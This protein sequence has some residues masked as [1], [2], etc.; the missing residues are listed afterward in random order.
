[1]KAAIACICALILPSIP[2]AAQGPIGYAGLFTSYEHYEW[3]VDGEA[4]YH[5]EMWIWCFPSYLGQICAEFEVYYPPNVYESAITWNTPLISSWVGCPA[6]G[7]SVCFI[8]CQW[9][10]LWICHQSLWVT[11]STP[12]YCEIIPH[13]DVGVYQFANCAPGYPTEPF[14]KLANFYINHSYM[15]DECTPFAVESSSWGA[16]KSIAR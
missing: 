9:D 5:A 14:I 16:I 11:D 6:E 15:D 12:S 4:P 7:F 8:D 13:H 10:W 1:M 2:C 3:C